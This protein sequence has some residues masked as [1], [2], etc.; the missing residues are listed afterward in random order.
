AGLSKASAIHHG[1][2]N[3]IGGWIARRFV[4]A[5]PAPFRNIFSRSA[6]HGHPPKGSAGPDLVVEERSAVRGPLRH[7]VQ[8]ALPDS[9]RPDLAAV[10]VGDEHVRV[11]S[12]V[13]PKKATE[14]PAHEK[15][16]KPIDV[17]VS[18]STRELPVCVSWITRD[19]VRFML[20]KTIR[21]PSEDTAGSTSS[22]APVVNASGLP[23]A[24]GI[25]QRVRLPARAE[26][27]TMDFP[28]GVHAGAP[29]SATSNETRRAPPPTAETTQ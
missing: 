5:I 2:G 1:V 12:F 15:R 6:G 29:P 9:H 7:D 21:R 11:S 4:L 28:S 17:R 23:R 26:L 16:G 24:V 13:F 20:A 18:R 10:A 22:P 14:R 25:R 8:L 3:P 19:Q 27:T